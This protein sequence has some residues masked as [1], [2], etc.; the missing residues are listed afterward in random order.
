MLERIESVVEQQ[1]LLHFDA[2]NIIAD[3]YTRILRD[4][5]NEIPNN[6]LV[7]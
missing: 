4:F 5:A 7:S 1:T 6:T 2:H 3:F